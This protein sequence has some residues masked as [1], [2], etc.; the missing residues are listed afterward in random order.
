M[1]VRTLSAKALMPLMSV[2]ENVTMSMWQTV[3]CTY[4]KCLFHIN[5]FLVENVIVDTNS[6]STKIM[7]LFFL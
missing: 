1:T 5:I 2:V 6:V 3:L 4:L 7:K